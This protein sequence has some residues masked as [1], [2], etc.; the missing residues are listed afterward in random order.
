MVVSGNQALAGSIICAKVTNS[1]LRKV[2]LERRNIS[3]QF[4]ERLETKRKITACRVSKGNKLIAFRL[5]G[6]N[7]PFVTS[8]RGLAS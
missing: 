6:H 3:L 1:I 4:N 7:N 2:S 5:D 8:V